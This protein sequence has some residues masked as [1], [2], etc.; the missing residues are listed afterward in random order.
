M[1]EPTSGQEKNPLQEIAELER[2]LEEKKKALE[3]EG[4]KVEEKEAFKE[5]FRETYGGALAPPAVT[6]AQPPPSA[7]LKSFAAKRADDLKSKERE[8]QISDLVAMALTRGIGAA[9]DAARQ[10][11]PWLMDELHDRLQDRYYE[12]LIQRKK[13]KQL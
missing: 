10:T 11:T 4:K 8:R 7:P 9:A 5:T 12:E 3:A 6:P 2:L 1:A 13:L